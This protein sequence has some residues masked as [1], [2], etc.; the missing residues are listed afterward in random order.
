MF[1][2]A[3]RTIWALALAAAI[4]ATAAET[5]RVASYN[6]R[7]YL[8]MDRLVEGA[9]RLDYP[10]PEKE[11]AV[12]RAT[13]RSVEPD[14]LAL[15]EIGSLEFLLELRDDLAREGLRYDGYAIAEAAD[16]T[17]RLG[18]LWK[19]ERVIEAVTHADIA[20][21]YFGQRLPM[22]RG[23]LEL[24]L[25]RGG[26]QPSASIFV[27]HLKSRYTDDRRDTQSAKRRAREAQAARDRILELFPDPSNQ[28]FLIV[29][30]L[31]DGPDSGAVG[32]FIAKGRRPLTRMIELTDRSGLRWT[33]DY[34]KAGMYSQI[35]Y[36]L[37]SP[38]WPGMASLRGQIADRPDY[39]EGSDHRL[40]WVDCPLP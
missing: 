15:Q 1:R 30:D 38:G 6:V 23:L 19:A 11:K 26:S 37:V 14:I 24:K 33:H 21:T 16:E 3:L 8:C 40:I 31:N 7:N 22:K 32:R 17:R 12:V 5:L 36:I 34:R 2:W 20:F 35:D 27:A 39:Y 13:I 28:R 10:K 9:F 18:A 29:G 25:G 4:P